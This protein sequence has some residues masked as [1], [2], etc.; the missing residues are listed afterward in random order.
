MDIITLS[1]QG[2][3]RVSVVDIFSPQ[4]FLNIKNFTFAPH[5]PDRQTEVTTGHSDLAEIE[6]FP[7]YTHQSMHSADKKNKNKQ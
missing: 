4:A 2:R 6:L 5:S 7:H 1:G 3:L